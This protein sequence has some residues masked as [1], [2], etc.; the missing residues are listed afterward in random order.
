MLRLYGRYCTL[1]GVQTYSYCEAG[2]TFCVLLPD[3]E[4]PEARVDCVRLWG[5]GWLLMMGWPGG[6]NG[7]EWKLNSWLIIYRL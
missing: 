5:I 1:W 2:C 3:R 4:S 7:I 6:S